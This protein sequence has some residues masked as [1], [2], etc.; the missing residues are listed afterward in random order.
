MKFFGYLLDEINTD[1]KELA[2]NDQALPAFISGLT[3]GNKNKAVLSFLSLMNLYKQTSALTIALLDK[4][5]AFIPLIE[6]L[7]ICLK[8]S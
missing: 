7:I 1:L 3:I 8:D 2:K 6:L 5:Q 4:E